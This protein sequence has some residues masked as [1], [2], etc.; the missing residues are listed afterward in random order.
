MSDQDSAIKHECKIQSE[1]C[2]FTATALYEWLGRARLYNMGWNGLPI[3][4]GAVASFGLLQNAYPEIAS[5]FALIAGLLPSIY[6]KLQIQAHT[7]EI[8]TQ[9]GQ[10]KN[11][12]NRFNQAAAIT[13]LDANPDALKTEF[14]ALMR[15][16][17]D[18]RS[19]PLIIP[20]KYFQAARTKIKDG[21]YETGVKSP[22]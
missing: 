8:L 13:A 15:Q 17:E 20:E 22:T 6:E 11:L 19:R 10:Y 4:F 2:Q 18:L 16:V 9:A 12:E 7:D 21:R 14:S 3:A 1:S 5:F